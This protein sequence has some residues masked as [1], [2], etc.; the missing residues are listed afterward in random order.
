MNRRE[1]VVSTFAGVVRLSG[2]SGVPG[3]AKT[4]TP[5]LGALAEAKSLKLFNR[6]ASRFIDSARNGVR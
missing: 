2:G 3:Q 1:F 4:M 6:G 5:D